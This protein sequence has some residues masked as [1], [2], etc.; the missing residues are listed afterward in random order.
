MRLAESTASRSPFTTSGQIAIS[1][2]SYRVVYRSRSESDA[3]RLSSASLPN[4]SLT[5]LYTVF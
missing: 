4:H 3:T 2:R 5:S 1:I